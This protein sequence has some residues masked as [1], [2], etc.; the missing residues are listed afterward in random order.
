MKRIDMKTKNEPAKHRQPYVCPNC[1]IIAVENENA[2]L[3]GSPP[4]G[5]TPIVV[6]P[7]VDDNDTNLDDENNGAPAKQFNLWK[8]EEV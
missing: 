2:I 5:T 7:G 3:A 1:E 6:P 4:I 8:W